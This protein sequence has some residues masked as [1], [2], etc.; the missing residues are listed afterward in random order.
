MMKIIGSSLSAWAIMSFTRTDFSA[1][2]SRLAFDLFEISA[3]CGYL[4]CHGGKI[5]PGKRHD[6][7]G[8]EARSNDFI[9][10]KGGSYERICEL[11]GRTIFL[12]D[13]DHPWRSIPLP[14]AYAEKQALL[15]TLIVAMATRNDEREHLDQNEWA[16][17][18]KRW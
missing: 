9:I 14:A 2:G 12:S 18:K 15:T 17:S 5:S 1:E 4:R 8:A 6:R 16:S 3:T 7:P 10:D 13:L 11:F